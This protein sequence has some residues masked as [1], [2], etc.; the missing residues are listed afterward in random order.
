MNPP[1]GKGRLKGQPTVRVPKSPAANL[2]NLVEVAGVLPVEKIKTVGSGVARD[3]P[4]NQ[5]TARLAAQILGRDAAGFV[6]P[7]QRQREAILVAFVRAGYV[8]YGKA[9]DIVR[10]TANVDLDSEDSIRRHLDHLI[11]YEIK[12]TS[13]AKVA[14]D[15]RGHFF[16]MSTAELLVAQNLGHRY[17]FVFVNTSTGKYV[18]MSLS[19][20][21]SKARGIY[22]SWSIMF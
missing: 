10:V 12:S 21:F 9:F 14:D 15:F 5:A 22:P 7:T 8:I 19:E 3:R 13:K 16:S 1:G 18:E 20:L 6:V 2:D 17:R 11:L 4:S